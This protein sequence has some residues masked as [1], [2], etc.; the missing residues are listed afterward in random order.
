MK[1]LLALF[2]MLA[3]LGM[4]APSYGYILIY[5]AQIYGKALDLDNTS[6][7][8]G[9]VKAYVVVA[10]GDG[11]PVP[12][13][14]EI[15]TDGCDGILAAEVIFYDRYSGP[16]FYYVDS[17]D[18]QLITPAEDCAAITINE[19]DNDYQCNLVG[20]LKPANIGLEGK[21]YVAKALAGS[22]LMDGT[23][24]DMADI[25]GAA[26]V[27]ATLETKLTKMANTVDVE[28]EQEAFGL[29]MDA[30]IGGLEAKGFRDLSD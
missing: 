13:S 26:T 21:R 18:M 17:P 27:T 14:A 5:K 15:V 9:K 25:I 20:K 28:S 7:E 23:F 16:K 29:M 19:Y 8:Y 22:M 6:I 2:I 4:C 10:I 3:V 24:F 12:K 11:E 1:R 30:I